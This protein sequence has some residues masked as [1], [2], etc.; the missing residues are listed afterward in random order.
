[1]SVEREVIAEI[2]GV[3]EGQVTCE[4]CGNNVRHEGWCFVWDVSVKDPKKFCTFWS[5]LHEGE[6]DG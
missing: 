4:K 2:M 6:K 1:M 3:T 5:P